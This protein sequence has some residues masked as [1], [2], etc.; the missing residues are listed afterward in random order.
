MIVSFVNRWL[1]I[2]RILFMLDLLVAS[3][4]SI[5]VRVTSMGFRGIPLCFSLKGRGFIEV[6]AT[7]SIEGCSS[8]AVK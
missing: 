7:I 6:I 3:W 1:T 4:F 2:H 5:S 8:I